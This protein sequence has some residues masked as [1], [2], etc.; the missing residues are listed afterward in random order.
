MDASDGVY[1]RNVTNLLPFVIQGNFSPKLLK[2]VVKS[3][4]LSLIYCMTR[5]TNT[6]IWHACLLEQWN[7]STDGRQTG[8]IG[9]IPP[10]IPP[11]VTK[12]QTTLSSTN[13]QVPKTHVRTTRYLELHTPNVPRGHASSDQ[14]GSKNTNSQNRRTK[15]A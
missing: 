5:S 3:P 10:S 11:C 13:S 12:L 15:C 4:A 6:K 2:H 7:G 8:D 14:H 1:S 9:R